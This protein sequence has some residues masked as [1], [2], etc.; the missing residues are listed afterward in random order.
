MKYDVVIGNPPYNKLL[1][2]TFFRYAIKLKPE[3]ILYLT[4]DSWQQSE[5][6]PKLFSQFDL[7]TWKIDNPWA[8]CVKT[9]VC[10]T[11]ITG[12]RQSNGQKQYVPVGGREWK[13]SEHCV[14]ICRS[15]STRP[16][17]VLVVTG[18]WRPISGDWRYISCADET[19][20]EGVRNLI[21]LN[22]A[23]LNNNRSAGWLN[24][25]FLQKLLV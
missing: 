6:L 24:K 25:A 23:L 22:S 3:H 5:R 17:T 8:E 16:D 20:A 7:Q 18:D 21:L 1:W 14:A 12:I 13:R 9:S 11:H 10:I 15:R 19:D 2:I 4:P